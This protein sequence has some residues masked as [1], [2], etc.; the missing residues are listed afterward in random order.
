MRVLFLCDSARVARFVVE[1]GLP[2]LRRYDVRY[3]RVREVLNSRIEK[4]MTAASSV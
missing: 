3:R 4:V 2:F 1:Q